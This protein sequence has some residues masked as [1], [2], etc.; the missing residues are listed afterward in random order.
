MKR[1]VAVTDGAR[2]SLISFTRASMIETVSA[3]MTRHLLRPPAVSGASGESRRHRVGFMLGATQGSPPPPPHPPVRPPLRPKLLLPPP[4]PPPPTLENHD[5][6]RALD[7][8]QPVR[9]HE[10]R[11]PT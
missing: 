9:D 4:P 11:P 1:S 7:R 5:P 2:S 6:T 10:R 3:P 8:R